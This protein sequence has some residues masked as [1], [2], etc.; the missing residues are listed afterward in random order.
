[1]DKKKYKGV[2]LLFKHE[3]WEVSLDY[4]KRNWRVVA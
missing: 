4:Q 2:M 1:M 3:N